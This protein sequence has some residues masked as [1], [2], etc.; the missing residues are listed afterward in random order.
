[1]KKLR[2]QLFRAMLRA[3]NLFHD[4]PSDENFYRLA[5]ATALYQNSVRR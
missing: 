4:D 5:N 1:M 3:E 2:V